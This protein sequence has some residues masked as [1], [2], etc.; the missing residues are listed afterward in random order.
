[1]YFFYGL[2]MDRDA[3]QAQGLHP[4]PARPASVDG[5]RLHIGNRAALAREQ[6]STVWGVVM[7]LPNDEVERLYGEPSVADYRPEAV[8]ARLADGGTTAA[9]CYNHQGEYLAGSN[10]VYAEA[11]HALAEKIVLPKDYIAFLEQLTK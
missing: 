8:L 2:F 5:Y 10:K 4:G 6:G 1:M 3:L 9:L 11:L 7:A